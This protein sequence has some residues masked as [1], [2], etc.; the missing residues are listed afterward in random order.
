MPG[1]ESLGVRRPCYRSCTKLGLRASAGGGPGSGGWP[2]PCRQ[3]WPWS[4]AGLRSRGPVVPAARPRIVLRPDT[5]G[6]YIRSYPGGGHAGTNAVGGPVRPTVRGWVCRSRLPADSRRRRAAGV[7]SMRRLGA[8]GRGSVRSVPGQRRGMGL[9]ELDRPP[10]GVTSYI[11]PIRIG[12]AFAEGAHRRGGCGSS[13]QRG[14][15]KASSGT[16]AWA[17]G[18][19]PW[20]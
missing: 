14:R 4:P 13:A 15:A 9:V 1:P 19:Q 17:S 16:S 20:P 7:P 10:R 18:F 6:A 3:G 2:G 5:N 11:S 12:G 8:P